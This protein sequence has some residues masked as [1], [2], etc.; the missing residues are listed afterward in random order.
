[1]ETVIFV[2]KEYFDK[3][4]RSKDVIE[5]KSDY[6]PDNLLKLYKQLTPLYSN[7]ELWIKLINRVSPYQDSFDMKMCEWIFN[8]RKEGIDVT[9]L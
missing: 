1:M 2:T 6:E 3:Y 5:H 4:I 7:S 8:K 9:N